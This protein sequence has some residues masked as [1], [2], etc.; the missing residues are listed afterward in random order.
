M[1]DGWK[2]KS[3]GDI[4]DVVTG[5][6]PPTSD[7]TNYGDNL[8][9]VS[10]AD[11]GAFKYISKSEKHL[12]E[13]GA[14]KARI[15][16]VGT[17]LFTCIGSTIGKVGLTAVDLTTNQQINA[18]IPK[19]GSVYEEYLY[20]ALCDIAPRVKRIAG[21][22]AV[23]IIN[24]TEFENQ[25]IYLPAN[26][27]EQKA[28]A[29]LLSTWDEA[30]EK[31]ERLIL[32][33]EDYL[34]GQIQKLISQRCDSWS[35]I[36]PKKIFDTITEKN[37]PDEELLSVTQD[38]GVIP[39]SMLEGRV[40]SPDGTT[41]S[42]K[43]IKRGDFAISLRSFQGGIEYSNYQGIISP[44]YTVLRPK[45]E[46][47]SDFYRL[48]FKSYIFIEKYLNLAVIGIRDGK[49]ISIPDFLSIKIPVPPLEQQKEIAE[50][51][52]VCQHEIDLLKQ[53]ADK[54]KTQKRGLMQKMLTG[55]WR[56]KPEIVNQYREA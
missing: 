19:N 29:T 48:F 25:I 18:A 20:Y 32:A 30:I 33:K 23:P 31:I 50:T 28:I 45:I 8:P 15:L 43:L 36:K 47:S 22:Q 6:T 1:I 51:L 9:F 55:E 21:V 3:V 12:S 38:R 37:F 24:K 49:Q 10:P 52:S 13:K 4:A 40:M 42:Y 46:L 56:V 39:R 17:S 5:K 2:K 54:Y 44:A 7:K 14:K 53:L 26:I 41:A 35:H 34:K 16:P 11:L 27:S